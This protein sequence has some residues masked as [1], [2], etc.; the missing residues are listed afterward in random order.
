MSI[1]T[2]GITHRQFA[3]V[4]NDSNFRSSPFSFSKQSFISELLINQAVKHVMISTYFDGSSH[5]S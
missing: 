5:N 3:F 2:G 1:F 4:N